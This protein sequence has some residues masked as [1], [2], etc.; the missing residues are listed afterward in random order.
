M[1]VSIGG[2][3]LSASEL[4][5]F[6]ARFRAAAGEHQ[7]A[8]LAIINGSSQGM[9]EAGQDGYVWRNLFARA[10]LAGERGFY[11][12]S[13]S[14]HPM[15]A[16][17]TWF[18]DR[19][20]G[21][22]GV[23]VE[24]VREHWGLLQKHRSCTLAREC[25]SDRQRSVSI[26]VRGPRSTVGGEWSG[27]S[28]N[29]TC[30]PIS[31]IALREGR[32]IIDFWSLDVEGHELEALSHNWEVN[33]VSV[34]ALLVEDH[35][36]VQTVLDRLVLTGH[37]FVKIAQMPLDSLYT[38]RLA[39]RGLPLHAW[40]SPQE[41]Q[42]WESSRLKFRSRQP[43]GAG[44]A[45]TLAEGHERKKAG[46]NEGGWNAFTALSGKRRRVGSQRFAWTPPPRSLAHIALRP[47]V[48]FI[49]VRKPGVMPPVRGSMASRP[50]FSALT[51]LEKRNFSERLWDA[52]RW[53]HLEAY[54][55]SIAAVPVE[56]RAKLEG[57]AYAVVY[58]VTNHHS[59]NPVG[60]IP[61]FVVNIFAFGLLDAA[62]KPMAGREVLVEL[63]NPQRKFEFFDCR[64]QAIRGRFLLLCNDMLWEV[65]LELTDPQTSYD[66]PSTLSCPQ[67]QSA[68]RSH[69][70]EGAR[71]IMRR[72]LLARFRA[73]HLWQVQR[74]RLGAKQ[75]WRPIR[76]PVHQGKNL[77]LYEANGTVYLE[78]WTLNPAP[79]RSLHEVWP[80][81]NGSSAPFKTY[82]SV[83][84]DRNPQGVLRAGQLL[85]Q[86]RGGG[87]CISLGGAHTGDGSPELLVGIGHYKHRHDY[88]Y[89]HYLYAMSARPPFRIV[90][91]STAFC[92]PSLL[93]RE[94]PRDANHSN[95]TTCERVQMSMSIA[96]ASDD[97]QRAVITYGV[98]DCASRAV[99][100]SKVEI[101]RY[102]GLHRTR[103]GERPLSF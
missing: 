56:L 15:K 43:G 3:L 5:A 28:R 97:S 100:V 7:D 78:A 99:V 69:A 39:S 31:T 57:A 16:S 29:V 40:S 68:A 46:A 6:A 4:G 81:T 47:E 54:N 41:V 92:W 14:W 76:L 2:P 65:T 42:V 83:R 8:C 36:Q 32:S 11:V 9:G 74:R 91:V 64:L 1:E 75:P 94:N 95:A 103:G 62:L 49:K 25:V 12:E 70:T 84:S 24:P 30:V 23:C 35:H 101:A 59:C 34:N 20:L 77:N 38:S 87:C 27:R 22:S 21:W 55:P 89:A 73:P 82:E 98:E 90:A 45:A 33:G 85:S 26:S 19:C 60:S 50:A 37:N 79:G 80:L 96:E 13:G 88:T 102:L 44:V 58:R 51:V 61:G 93:S 10:S 17:N 53:S 48:Q 67:N 63:P 52:G 18:F 66:C 72:G 86:P 71:H